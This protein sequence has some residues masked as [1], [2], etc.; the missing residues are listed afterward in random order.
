[1]PAQILPVPLIGNG[2]GVKLTVLVV[3]AAQ[4]ALTADAV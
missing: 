1:M 3:V 4:L 2:V